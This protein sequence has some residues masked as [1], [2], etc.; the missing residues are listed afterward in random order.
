MVVTD[1]P[2]VGEAVS[3][4]LS[5]SDPQLDVSV[6]RPTGQWSS[7]PTWPPA[8]AVLDVA[9][10][11]ERIRACRR[12]EDNSVHVVAIVE[13]PEDA[14]RVLQAGASGVVTSAEGL[15]GVLE[16]VDSISHGRIYV[17][18]EMLGDVLHRLIDFRQQT[19]ER[20]VRVRRL[21]RREHQVL[22]LLGEGE[23]Q[24]GIARRLGISPETAKTHVRHVMYKLG[25]R[26]RAEAAAVAVDLGITHVDA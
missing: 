15:A 9:S 12:L 8:V 7:V 20:S 16:A 4:V 1:R 13:R 22:G 2:A 5:E 14:L 19:V 25:V 3:R 21:S 6:A 11:P 17:P 23:D 10:G 26:T 18:E 24:G